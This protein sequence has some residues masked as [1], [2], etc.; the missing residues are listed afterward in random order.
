NFGVATSLDY[1][2]HPIGP[3]TSG[4]IYYPGQEARAVVRFFRNF[5]AEAPDFF[6]ATL[7]LTRGE[8][9]AFISLCHAGEESEA[10]RLLRALRTVAT[11]AKESIRRQEYSELAG[12]APVAARDVSFRCYATVYRDEFSND[13]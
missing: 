2:L 13:V 9:G 11:P 8:R 7:N 10:D 1:R 6:Q 4:D 12:R 5:M 3:V